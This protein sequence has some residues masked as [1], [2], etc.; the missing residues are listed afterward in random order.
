MVD[1]CSRYWEF[2]K[3]Y[4]TDAATI[5]QYSTAIQTAKDLLEKTKEDNIGPYLA[6]LEAR[7]TPVDNYKYPAKLAYRRQL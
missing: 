2:E 4:K 5:R 1:Y 3:L 7:N 6:M